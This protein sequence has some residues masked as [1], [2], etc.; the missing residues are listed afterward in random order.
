MPNVDY[1]ITP[2]TGVPDPYAVTNLLGAPI[3]LVIPQGQTTGSVTLTGL[4]NPNSVGDDDLNVSIVSINGTAPATPQSANLTLLNNTYPLISAQDMSIV[5]TSPTT[6]NVV[7]SLNAPCHHSGDRYYTT[8][9]NTAVAGTDYTF[10]SGS[11][12]FS[13]GQTV[14]TIPISLLDNAGSDGKSFYVDLS[15]P[16]GDRGTVVRSQATVTLLTAEPPQNSGPTVTLS[17]T[18]SS[19]SSFAENGGSTATITANL[20]GISTTD[21]LINLSF[22]GTATFGTDYTASGISILSRR[23]RSRGASRSPAITWASVPAIS[24]FS[25]ESSRSTAPLRRRFNSRPRR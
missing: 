22:A 14:Q 16:A 10:D 12:T 24:T 4:N 8:K 15:V 17:L 7:V 9:D 2:N 5:E 11:M 21:T 25:W 3:E 6:A 1:S 23:D 13:P 18:Y 19:G 20:A